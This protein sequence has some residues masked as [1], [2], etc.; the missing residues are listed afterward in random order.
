MFKIFQIGK[1]KFK[2]FTAFY[3][4][5]L[6]HRKCSNV[7]LQSEIHKPNANFNSKLEV[8]KRFLIGA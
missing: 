6:S 4:S 8:E 7:L 5:N 3:G 1:Q 2:S